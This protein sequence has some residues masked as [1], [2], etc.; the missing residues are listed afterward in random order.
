MASLVFAPERFI[1]WIIVVF[2]AVAWI[3]GEDETST[4]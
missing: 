1:G 2:L 3:W 4:S